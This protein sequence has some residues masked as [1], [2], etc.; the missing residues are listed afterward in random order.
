MLNIRKDSNIN[1]LKLFLFFIIL[2]PFLDIGTTFSMKYISSSITIGIAV[3]MLFL[4]LAII[5]IFL[6]KPSKLKTFSL[7]LLISFAIISFLSFLI[8]FFNKPIFDFFSEAQFYA[9]GM[10]F[11]V[12]F[13]ASLNAIKTLKTLDNTNDFLIVKYITIAMTIVS[14]SIIISIVTGTSMM[15]YAYSSFGFKGWFFA[16]NEIGAI[17]SIGITMTLLYAH[18]KTTS[19][20]NLYYWIPTV[21]LTICLIMLGTKVS[22]LSAVLVLGSVL[23]YNIINLIIKSDTSIKP[24]NIIVSIVMLGIIYVVTPYTPAFTNANNLVVV[25]EVDKEV[26]ENTI[27]ENKNSKKENKGSKKNLSISS[28]SFFESSVEKISPFLSSR[29]LFLINTHNSYIKAPIS[30]KI[31]GTGYSG[32]YTKVAKT[33]E[34]D[35][36][37]LFY[38]Y[39]LIGSIVFLSPLFYLFIFIIV[40]FKKIKNKLFK[41][42]FVFSFIALVLGLAIAG[43]SG[44]VLFA[45]SVSIYL[46]II[47][48]YIYNIL[49][50]FE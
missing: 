35:F 39:G 7:I 31:F 50:I 40:K 47:I 1:F 34:M 12:L 10:Y 15:T 25:D 37:D 14:L 41:P 28:Q 38:S 27:K 42:D 46:A 36:F 16:G 20:S 30:Q 44:H 49:N 11:I 43:F 29:D 9:K 3:R 23:I 19:I 24:I 48:A 4:V 26:I 2:Q 22:F 8:G 17:M 6:Q 45:P 18:K 13:L 21:L 33:I 5:T 32:N